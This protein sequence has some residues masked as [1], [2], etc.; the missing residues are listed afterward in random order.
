VGNALNNLSVMYLDLGRFEQAL[1]SATEGADI[2]RATLGDGNET[3]NI[4]RLNASR[5]RIQLGDLANAESELRALIAT[6]RQLFNTTN[7]SFAL[8]VDT[9][10]DVLNRQHEYAEA[11]KVAR[12]AREAVGRT[13]GVDHWRWAAVNRTFG[14]ALAG[15]GRY[16]EAEPILL[17][18]YELMRSKR[19]EQHR[20]TSMVA[21]R[22]VELYTSWGKPERAA[23]WQAKIGPVSR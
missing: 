4:T 20:A 8:T 7:I 12:E 16:A 13:A 3:T 9:L 11:L 10:A 19:G 18:S 23:E 15:L 17:E 21:Q 2:L 22:V 5:A 6:R 14:T 1:A